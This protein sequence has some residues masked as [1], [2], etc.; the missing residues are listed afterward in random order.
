[1]IDE[2]VKKAED[3]GVYI[4]KAHLRIGEPEKELIL[5]TQKLGAGLVVVAGRGKIR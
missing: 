2:Q 5:L 4:I 3:Y 1:M